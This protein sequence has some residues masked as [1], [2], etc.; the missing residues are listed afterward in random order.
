MNHALLDSQVFSLPGG[1]FYVG[2]ECNNF[3]VQY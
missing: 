1:K 2:S 3:N